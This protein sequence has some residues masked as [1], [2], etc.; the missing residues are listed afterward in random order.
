MEKELFGLIKTRRSVREFKSD[1]IPRE[2]VLRLVEAASW[3]PSGSNQQP[4]RFV[5]VSNPLVIAQMAAAVRDA[6]KVLS[7]R[8]KSV[9][10]REEFAAYSRYF[11]VF[12]HAPL[13]LCVY[14]ESYQPLIAR[15]LARYGEEDKDITSTGSIQSCAAAVQNL[16]LMAHAMGLGG[17]WMT[18][19]V[20]AADAIADILEVDPK[21]QL[22]CVL[23][24]GYPAKVPEPPP[25]PNPDTLV[26]FMQAAIP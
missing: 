11:T 10:A 22:I 19:P 1:P 9:R 6:I 16:L 5:A 23:A 14:S 17:C 26:K 2:V 20:I 21:W 4:W 25:R 15:L 18:G 12:E 24:L 3:A 13:A 7:L 8:M